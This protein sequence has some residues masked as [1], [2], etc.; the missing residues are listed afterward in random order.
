MLSHLLLLTTLLA[1][2]HGFV[3]SPAFFPPRASS[4]R[5]NTLSDASPSFRPLFGIE[6]ENDDTLPMEENDAADG[7]DKTYAGGGGL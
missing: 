6:I 4:G 1:L 7:D 5:A 3:P 2:A